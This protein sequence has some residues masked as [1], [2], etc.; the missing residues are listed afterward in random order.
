[1]TAPLG[2]IAERPALLVLL[3]LALLPWFLP[4]RLRS[5]WPWLGSVPQ[6]RTSLLLDILLKALAALA[7]AAL[8]LAAA[9]LARDRG[10]VERISQGA[11]IALVIDRSSSMNDTFGGGT[12][13]GTEVSKATAAKRLLLSFLERRAHDR[14]GVVAFSTA[15]IFV[16]P[17]TEHHDAVR[18]A[19]DAID[20][21]GL[22]Y[23]DVARGL[24]M[25]LSMFEATDGPASRVVLLV[26]D[27]AAVIDHR[28]QERL[29]AAVLA[30]P[31]RLY[32]LFLKT[33]R[34]RGPF[35]MPGPEQED[36]PRQMPERHLH[37]FFSS[38]GI[39]Y[40]AFQADGVDDLA[41]A[42]D[43]IDRSE[44][45][46]LSY[47]ETLPRRDLV[48]PLCV[49]AALACF[50]LLLSRLAEVRIGIDPMRGTR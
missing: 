15:P 4:T 35:D 22:A 23:T 41:H 26:S 13:D 38:L 17:L 11:H 9:G 1:M 31:V 14:I 36:T 29:R 16:L 3:A 45:R 49:V 2:L 21:P 12:P 43:E 24:A 34:G 19:I 47:R 6:D 40:K 33:A 42:I 30:H 10:S 8:A 5:T 28:V 25:A 37:L 7:I 44:S 27:G 18:A 48:G 46:P 32:W 20:L 39:P 50:A